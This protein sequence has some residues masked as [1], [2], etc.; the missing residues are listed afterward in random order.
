MEL[1]FTVWQFVRLM[2][3]LEERREAATSPRANEVALLDAWAYVWTPLDQDLA[4]LAESDPDGYAEMMMDQEVVFEEATAKQAA[5][6]A[7]TLEAV[8]S[9]MDREIEAGGDKTL[10]ESLKFER[11]EL[12]QLVRK[13][14]RQAQ[15]QA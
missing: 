5:T 13:L 3:H 14:E 9:Q 7:A 8:M 2:V 15:K 11:R 12:R 10:I 1:R 4:R 6:A